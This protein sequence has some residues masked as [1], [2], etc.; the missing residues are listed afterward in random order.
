ML[1]FRH[2][3]HSIGRAEIDNRGAMTPAAGHLEISLDPAHRIGH[4][5]RLIG[6]IPIMAPLLDIAVHVKKA[7]G[8]RRSLSD[9]ER[10]GD[11][12]PF[13]FL[14]LLKT[15]WQILSGK[16]RR[17][18]SRPAGVFPFGLSREPICPPF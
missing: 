6:P 7:P 16:E 10:N 4:G 2:R 9:L 17:G 8:V 14:M 3:S 13:L 1:V 12:S 11:R 18:C 5:R 15:A